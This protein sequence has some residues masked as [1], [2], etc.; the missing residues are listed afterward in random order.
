[1]LK[2]IVYMYI[3][4]HN[5]WWHSTFC[6]QTIPTSKVKT[7]SVQCSLNINVLKKQE[8]LLCNSK[9]M[10]VNV[11]TFAWTTSCFVCNGLNSN[12]VFFVYWVGIFTRFYVD[13]LYVRCIAINKALCLMCPVN[14]MS[15]I[16]KCNLVMRL[17]HSMDVRDNIKDCRDDW[18]WLDWF[19][20][21]CL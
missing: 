17:S 4:V 20:L 7:N 19:D 5:A 8:M 12:K 13:S 2:Y 6:L 14:T 11:H 1:M 21:L 15:F 18:I 3:F 10:S 16:H 9:W